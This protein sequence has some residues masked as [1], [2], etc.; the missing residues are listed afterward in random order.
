MKCACRPHGYAVPSLLAGE[1]TRLERT[2]GHVF[3]HNHQGS[4]RVSPEKQVKKRSICAASAALGNESDRQRLTTRSKGPNCKSP[5]L[6]I[7]LAER[8]LMVYGAGLS[9]G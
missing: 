5:L 6:G 8:N 3:P 1:G 4:M 7:D 9:I 2:F